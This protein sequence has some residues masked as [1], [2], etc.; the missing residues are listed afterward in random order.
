MKPKAPRYIVSYIGYQHASIGDD[1]A[2]DG[3]QSFYTHEICCNKLE[4]VKLF[5]KLKTDRFCKNVLI[6]EELFV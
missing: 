2:Y 1:D 6:S 5:Y 4:A 3:W